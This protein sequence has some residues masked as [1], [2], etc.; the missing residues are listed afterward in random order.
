MHQIGLK[1]P[2]SYYGGKQQLSSVILSLLPSHKAYNEPFFGGVAIFFAKR[3]C[4]REYI[5]DLNGA[6]INFYRVLKHNFAELKDMIDETLYSEQTHHEAKRLYNEGCDDKVR[7]AWAV[8]VL[9]HMSMFS[10]I[11]NTWAFSGNSNVAKK[12]QRCKEWFSEV[13]AQRLENTH[14]FCRDAVAQIKRVDRD[15]VLHF[16]DPPY[17]DTNCGHYKGYSRED[18]VSL[19][20]EL[21]RIKGKFLLS[22]YSNDILS[23]YAARFGWRQVE[24]EMHKSAGFTQGERKVEVLTYNYDAECDRQSCLFDY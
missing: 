20:E 2:I 23:E 8:F 18:Y 15:D 11:G 6:M 5:N 9:S 13:Y 21:S 7:W 17:I 16:C 1:T 10:I 4:E 12:W 3:P 14:I 22:S 19:L 24:I